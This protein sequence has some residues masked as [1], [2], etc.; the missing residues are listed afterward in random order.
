MSVSYFIVTENHGGT[1]RVHSIPGKGSTFTLSIPHATG[2]ST[3][4]G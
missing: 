4:A 1:I 3:T 2:E